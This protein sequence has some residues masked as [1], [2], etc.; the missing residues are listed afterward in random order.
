MLYPFELRALNHLA[1]L[2]VFGAVG[3][4]LAAP[5][6]TILPVSTVSWR[7]PR[8]GSHDQPNSIARGGSKRGFS[9]AHEKAQAP[10]NI[11]LLGLPLLSHCA[12]LSVE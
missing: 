12:A 11:G 10:A 1:G 2:A 5:R 3:V 4:A 7:I 9:G 6:K 8:D